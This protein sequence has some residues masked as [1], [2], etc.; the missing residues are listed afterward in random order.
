MIQTRSL[1]VPSDYARPM[2]P[3]AIQEAVQLWGRTAGRTAKL[4]WVAPN[5][6]VWSDDL[7]VFI[8]VHGGLACWS[9]Q[10]SCRVGDPG[11]KA[12]QEG[13]SKQA[14]EPTESVL[15]IEWDTKAGQ[16]VPMKLEQY[17]SAGI[18]GFLE[19]GDTWSGRGQF[20]SLAEAFHFAR[21]QSKEGAAKL[22]QTQ[23]NW[24]RDFM[25]DIRR[26]F[27]KIPFHRVGIDLRKEAP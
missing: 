23:R 27:F 19:K 4:V 22:K 14:A 2:A 18:V 26:Q 21:E 10:L 24:S 11:L 5:E 12:W 16:Y 17:G 6:R 1:I 20:N 8:D 7:R 13:R 25:S 3:L 15:L 9:V